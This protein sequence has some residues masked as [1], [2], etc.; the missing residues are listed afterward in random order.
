MSKDKKYSLDKRTSDTV[1]QDLSMCIDD[2]DRQNLDTLTAVMAIV[3][4]TVDMSFNFTEDS[5][6]AMEL[7]STAIKEKLDIN[8]ADDLE[9]LLRSPRSTEK[10]VVH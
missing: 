5:Y 6:E 8:S 10:K 3:K 7:I 1:M 2:W 9:F 4:F